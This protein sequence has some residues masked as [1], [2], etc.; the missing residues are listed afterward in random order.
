MMVKH[1]KQ[2][3]VKY[4]TSKKIKHS[5]FIG[6]ISYIDIIITNE[7]F[8]K[9]INE[10]TK[11]VIIAFIN[12]S[13][14]NDLVKINLTFIDSSIVLSGNEI[15]GEFVYVSQYTMYRDLMIN[16]LTLINKD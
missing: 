13:T 11:L 1:S 5:E 15:S 12:G 14:A 3:I 7:T 16:E 10:N 9:I 4:Y 8:G 2:V 6:I